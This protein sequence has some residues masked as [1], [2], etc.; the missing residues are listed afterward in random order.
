MEEGDDDEEDDDEEEEALQGQ[1]ADSPVPMNAEGKCRNVRSQV[2]ATTVVSS[3]LQNNINSQIT[4]TPVLLMCKRRVR[5][6]LY[7]DILCYSEE[8]PFPRG[9]YLVW[10]ALHSRC[11]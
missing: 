7:A 9:I 5:I 1:P 8:V 11:V 2:V 3:F 4:M 6:C 10:V